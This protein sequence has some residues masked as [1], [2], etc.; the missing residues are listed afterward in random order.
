MIRFRYKTDSYVLEEGIYVDD[1]FPT[2]TFDSSAVLSDAIVN[3]YYDVTRPMG[4][5]YYEVKAADADGQ[6]GYWSQRESIN[7]TGAGVEVVD[8]GVSRGFP[9]PVY[10]SRDTSIPFAAGGGAVSVFDIRGRVITRLDGSGAEVAWDLRDT[11][12]NLVA[13][14]IYF[15]HV[16]TRDR[17]ATRKIVILK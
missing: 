13:P 15:V 17:V 4:T 7:V 3:T 2:Q 11:D 14:G 9:N 16:D 5:Y 8:P 10:L 12:G 6:W 1:I